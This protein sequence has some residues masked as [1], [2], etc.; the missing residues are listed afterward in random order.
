[1]DLP[2]NCKSLND[3][4]HVT[5]I[6]GHHLPPQTLGEALAYATEHRA[7]LVYFETER[8]VARFGLVDSALLSR[9]RAGHENAA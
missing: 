1:M 8:Y 7:E 9:L 5:D 6:D 3:A 2:G 4:V